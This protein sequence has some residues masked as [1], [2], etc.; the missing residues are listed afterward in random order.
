MPAL[1]AAGT[2]AIPTARL[3]PRSLPTRPARDNPIGLEQPPAFSNQQ[4]RLRSRSP[5]PAGF[6]RVG[7]ATGPSSPAKAKS[8]GTNPT[9]QPAGCHPQAPACGCP[10]QSRPENVGTNPLPPC[11]RTNQPSVADAPK[12]LAPPPS[13][14]RRSP[15]GTRADGDGALSATRNQRNKANGPTRGVPPTS[16]CLWVSSADPPAKTSG[17]NPT[18]Q[19]AGCHPQAPACGCP[20]QPTGKNPSPCLRSRGRRPR[21]A[22]RRGRNK[23]NESTWGV[24]P[25][26][27]CLWVSSPSRPAKVT[28][29]TQRHAGLPRSPVSAPP[30]RP[31]CQR[32]PDTRSLSPLTSPAHPPY[33]RTPLPLCCLLG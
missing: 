11:G 7:S 5:P 29:Q 9:A 14:L 10:R 27:S 22:C 30:P 18:A 13:L 4:S 32:P 2:T 12:P 3:K 28:E 6:G 23:P 1:S 8:D 26:S 25:T 20:R 33:P 21:G 15:G 31:R 24:P 19:P 17:T 16:S